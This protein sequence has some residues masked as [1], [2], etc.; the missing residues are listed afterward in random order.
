[1]SGG[2]WIHRGSIARPLGNLAALLHRLDAAQRHFERAT[3]CDRKFGAVVFT[4]FDAYDHA[5]FL[6]TAGGSSAAASDLLAEVLEIA[7]H[8]GLEQ[9]H[10]EARELRGRLSSGR[11]K[12]RPTGSTA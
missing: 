6:V 12:G 5:R 4:A 11:D 10:S 7:G 1:M 8:V 3:E 9:L 2:A